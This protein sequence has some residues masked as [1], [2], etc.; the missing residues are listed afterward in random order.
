MGLATV[1]YAEGHC[2]GDAAK[3]VTSVASWST[4]SVLQLH[5]IKQLQQ[6]QG[7]T[8]QLS[9]MC[10][11]ELVVERGLALDTGRYLPRHTPA[12]HIG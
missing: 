8:K 7:A 9:C 3:G 6:Q 2:A 5:Y 1:Q 4:S 11:V 12:A 10:F